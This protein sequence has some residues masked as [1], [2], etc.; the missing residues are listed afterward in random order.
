MTDWA[1]LERV[2]KYLNGTPAQVLVLRP[3]SLDV[4]GYVDAAFGCHEDGKSHTGMV[5]TVGGATVMCM[6]S[7]QKIVT[8]D[9][10]EAERQS[11]ECLAVS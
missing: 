4:E 1:K 5:V 8:E 9:S 10:T 2:L 3:T 11:H 7:K 6:S